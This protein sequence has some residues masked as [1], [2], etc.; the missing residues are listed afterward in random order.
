MKIKRFNESKQRTF[1]NDGTEE[2]C[3]V[4]NSNEIENSQSEYNSQGVTYSHKCTICDFKWYEPYM[5]VDS[6]IFDEVTG[7]E[8]YTGD[9]VSNKSYNELKIQA[10]KFNI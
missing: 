3:P 10:N 1:I 9:P 2:T 6:G 5:L 8:I 7:D 4:C